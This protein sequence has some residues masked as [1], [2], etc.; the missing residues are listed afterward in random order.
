MVSM[1]LYPNNSLAAD[2]PLM[3][4]DLQCCRFQCPWRKL[5]WNT[6]HLFTFCL[7][8]FVC[9]KD[10]AEQLQERPHILTYLLLFLY[11]IWLRK[12]SHLP[13]WRQEVAKSHISFLVAGTDAN[14]P[15]DYC[16]KPFLWC[17]FQY[18]STINTTSFE[19]SQMN[20]VMIKP[21]Y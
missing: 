12:R 19:N 6:A 7:S 1:C 15:I 17:F 14:I 10:R 5:Y 4:A 16:N 21:K 18:F 8:E 2:G 9:Y 11:T 20:P 3:P 13:H